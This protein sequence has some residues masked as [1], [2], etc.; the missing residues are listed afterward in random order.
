MPCTAPSNITAVGDDTYL[1]L[2]SYILRST[3]TGT[4]WQPIIVSTGRFAVG[5]SGLF[6]SSTEAVEPSRLY[7]IPVTDK[8]EN[9][10]LV[11]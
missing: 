7:F 3:D 8:L 10:V 1:L 11:R 2:G 5:E 6:V 4:T 9:G